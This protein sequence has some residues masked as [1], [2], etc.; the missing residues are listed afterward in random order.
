M[1]SAQPRC[2][3]VILTGYPAL[4]SALQAIR[5]QVDDYL[6]KPADIDTIIR[7]LRKKLASRRK[8]VA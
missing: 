7:V 5:T 8:S 4:E 2:V 6:V 3:N 1:R